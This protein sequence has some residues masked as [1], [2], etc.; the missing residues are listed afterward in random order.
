MASDTLSVVDNRTGRQ[1]TLPISDGAIRAE[2]LRQIKASDGDFGLVS[3]DP[4]LA[5]TAS[6]RSAI[7]Y[8]DGDNGVLLYRGYPI[9]QLAEKSTF[10]ETAYLITYGELPIF[11]VLFAIPRTVGWMA[12]WREMIADP[13]QRIVRPRQIYDGE[14]RRD[15]VPS[16]ARPG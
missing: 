10:L 5:N 2:E 1:Y 15:Y 7:T 14:G 11:P 9:E 13:E 8:I 12:Q 3:Y 16:G 6:C 4:S